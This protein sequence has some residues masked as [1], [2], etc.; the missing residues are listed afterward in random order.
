VD[1]GGDIPPIQWRF[2]VLRSLGWDVMEYLYIG[3]LAGKRWN[4]LLA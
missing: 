2:S 3:G 4:S 1:D